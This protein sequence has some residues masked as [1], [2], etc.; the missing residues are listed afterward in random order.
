M[1]NTKNEQ[2]LRQAQEPINY[3]D[4]RDVVWIKLTDEIPRV[5]QASGLHNKVCNVSPL[6]CTENTRVGYKHF[7]V[8]LLV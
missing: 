1:N 4:T 5:S 6:P 8:L 2:R 7:F 3:C